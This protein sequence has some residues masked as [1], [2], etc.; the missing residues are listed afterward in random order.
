LPESIGDPS[1][2]VVAED[3]VTEGANAASPSIIVIV[4][5]VE[6][7]ALR[8]F[9]GSISVMLTDPADDRRS[10]RIARWDFDESEVGALLSDGPDL[11]MT[12]ALPTETPT[13]RP[14]RLWVRMVD[15]SGSRKLQAT[16]VR[17]L[18]NPLRMVDGDSLAKA[19]NLHRL[20]APAGSK[21]RTEVVVHSP[22]GGWRASNPDTTDRRLDPAVAPAAYEAW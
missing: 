5:P 8:R 10:K 2:R 11:R 7:N 13:D 14:L 17:F 16:N 15:R 20:P 6:A 21:N 4:E 18:A 22:T 12:I 1:I 19:D 3:A 9:R